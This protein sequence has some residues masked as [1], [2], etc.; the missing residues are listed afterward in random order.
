MSRLTRQ[1]SGEDCH[2]L[3]FFP[4]T[5]SSS[6]NLNPRSESE[7]RRQNPRSECEACQLFLSLPPPHFARAGSLRSMVSV[8]G[9]LALAVCLV[10]LV[11]P[12][13]DVFAQEAARDAPRGLAAPPLIVESRPAAT[14]GAT[15]VSQVQGASLASASTYTR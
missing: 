11:A 14:E 15:S 5:H 12:P 3:G 7:G 9:T 8:A 4:T 6:R 10:L 13:G 1:G 2:F